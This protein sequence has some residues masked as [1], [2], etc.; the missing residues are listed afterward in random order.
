[1]IEGVIMKKDLKAIGIIVSVTVLLTV[2]LLLG[3]PS[4]SLAEPKGE[5]IVIGYVGNVASPG[6][7]PCMD[8][9]RMAVQEINDAGG[10]LGRPVKYVVMDGKGD[11]SLSVEAARKLIIEDKASFVSVE[12]RSEI[13]LAVQENSGNLFKEYPH[14]L[15][16]NGPMGSELTSR[17]IDE[18][19]KYDF[20][21]RDWDPEP[22]HYAQTKY[23]METWR[24]TIGV[25]KIAILWED[26][27]WTNEWR[28]G[29]DY[30]KLPTWEKMANEV[31]L[32]VVYS[33]GVKPRGTLYY[34]IL[35]EIAEKKADLI[36]F[37]SSWFTDTDAFARQWADSAAKDIYVSLYGGVAQ[38]YKYWDMTGGKALGVMTSFT[39][40]DTVPVTPKTI[41]LMK[42]AQ[43][44]NIPM[45]IH[46]HIAYADIYHFKA[47]IEVAKGTND[48]KRLIKGMED[49]TTEYSLGKMKY[50]TK[51][52]KP[53]Y[54]SRMRVD[55]NH[56]YKSY[57]GYY[58]QLLV[59]FQEGGKIA[60][61]F[62]SCAENEKAMKKFLN[63]TAV[64][65]PAQLRKIA[66]GKK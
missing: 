45:Q 52:V 39:D 27:A 56:P 65:T 18:A 64:K 2:T 23:I 57:P 48:I 51:K 17:V 49:V 42:K 20:C 3:V 19:P 58:Y 59:Q 53:F 31:G 60:Y 10:I 22:A 26:L 34:P 47:A 9:Q 21:F 13:S 11:T 44:N 54:H 8:I 32:E 33:K 40:L 50:E 1:M 61:L 12:G 16:F 14:I 55:P 43:R 29:I 7:K 46:V 30:I 38:T 37:V 63:P 15:V 62:E 41:P 28:K 35:Q 36:F 5:P 24:K 4:V 6:T 66:A 25:K